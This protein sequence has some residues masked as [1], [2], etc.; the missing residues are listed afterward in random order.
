MRKISL[1]SVLILIVSTAFSQFTTDQTIDKDAATLYL[2]SGGDVGPHGIVFDD[3]QNG[4]PLLEL[5][6]RSTPNQLI[7][8][9]ASNEADIFSI[10]ADNE[11]SYFSG[12]LGI[13][14]N[15]PTE[16]LDIVGNLA[17]TGQ[18]LGSNLTLDLNAGTNPTRITSNKV[19]GISTM[20][21][22]THSSASSS[23]QTR[24]LMRG[25]SLNDIE[26]YDKDQNQ[27]VNFDADNG[28][29]GI[30]VTNPDSKLVV[31]G[32]IRSE[33]V[34]VEIING[35]DYVFEENYELRTLQETKE[36]ITKNKHLPEIP[37]A[38]EMEANGVDL[39]DMNMRLLKKIQELTL[40]QIDLLEKLERQNERLQEVEDEL[41]TLKK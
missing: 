11:F 28:R 40:Y 37:T 29:V 10:D 12:R 19:G 5:V 32:K 39:G 30:G 18:I 36:F 34:K 2:G 41:Q 9:H 38:K 23:L 15:S 7:L 20:E 17:L 31:D 14:I 3:G 24:I 6:Y 8:E 16:S 4:S 1:T 27:F 22:Q 26:F 25:G 35:P 33:E 21:L 13:G